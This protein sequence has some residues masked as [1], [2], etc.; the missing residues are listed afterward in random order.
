MNAAEVDITPQFV[1]CAAEETGHQDAA[2]EAK[3]DAGDK[4]QKKDDLQALEGDWQP[5]SATR[6]GKAVS[7][8]KLQELR[9]KVVKAEAL[10][11]DVNSNRKRMQFKL[12]ETKNP[13]H[14][15]L[16]VTNGEKLLGIY[17][18]K[19]D[20]LR[21]ALALGMNSAAR[22]T[23]FEPGK[24]GKDDFVVVVY[25][26]DVP[27]AEDKKPDADR[28]VGVWKF[29]KARGDG[30]D[31]PPHIM[32]DLRLVF[33]KDGKMKLLNSKGE[34]AG[35]YKLDPA[36]KQI[37]L[38]LVKGD[39]KDA[40]AGI[41]KLEGQRMTLCFTEKN[42]DGKRPTEFKA[43]KGSGQV[44][45]ELA[46]VERPTDNKYSTSGGGPARTQMTNQFK[47]IGL[48]MH[49]YDATFKGM[50]AHAIYSKDGKT[51]L[52]SW[53]V[54]IL[55]FVEQN[56]LYQQFKLDEPWDSPHNKKLIPMMP[57]LYAPTVEV[58]GLQEGMT[59]YQVVTGWNTAFNGPKGIGFQ[60]IT[61]GTS[62]TIMIVEASDP[63]IWTKPADVVMP[64]NSRMAPKLGGLLGDIMVVGYFD[65]SV[66]I[67]NRN[68]PPRT[69]RALITP[70]GGE[71][72]GPDDDN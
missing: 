29:A 48:A 63:V 3:K 49:N 67:M 24:D 53:R 44:V 4:M 41:Y 38:M 40:V 59:F 20:T 31:A 9:L 66:R 71:V 42:K 2:Q 46:L 68:T 18:L 52:L 47:Q 70:N 37:D 35:E 8:E 45:F 13:K 25:K 21:L 32:A 60:Q 14:I 65:G 19:G 34:E 58:K 36:K 23:S 56:A 17:E 7:P 26:R 33:D 12:D 61:D 54:A 55:P 27:I 43:E 10:L 28:F 30:E 72:I 1:V 57:K 39:K 5:V 15:D 6:K 50:P 11:G 51:P 64:R 62:N 69:M 22:P 16:V